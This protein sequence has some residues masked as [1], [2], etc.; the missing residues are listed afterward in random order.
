MLKKWSP[1]TAAS[2][3]G[4]TQG[5]YGL[6]VFIIQELSCRVYNMIYL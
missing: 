3:N 4:P 2:F 1:A 6:S 5:S